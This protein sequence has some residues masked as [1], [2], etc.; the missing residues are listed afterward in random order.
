MKSRSSVILLVAVIFAVVGYSVVNIFKEPERRTPQRMPGQGAP[1]TLHGLV[2]PENDFVRDGQTVGIL[3]DR[4]GISLNAETRES[5]DMA[6]AD[7]S[8]Q[9]FV[10]PSDDI[11]LAKFRQNR[12]GATGA[13]TFRS[14]LVIYTWDKV[15]DALVRAGVARLDRSGCYTLDVRKL[16][17]MQLRGTTWRSLGLPSVSGSVRVAST[18]PVGSSCGRIWCALIASAET[19]QNLG[20][21]HRLSAALPAI[22]RS[23]A[24]S[25]VH[26]ADAQALFEQFVKLGMEGQPLAIGFEA[27]FAEHRMGFGQ[28]IS[29]TKHAIRILYPEPAIWIDHTLIPLTMNGRRLLLALDDPNLLSYS[30]SKYGFRTPSGAGSMYQSSGIQGMPMTIENAIDVPTPAEMKEIEA[31]LKRV[32]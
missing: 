17:D 26:G 3:R 10:W 12:P 19:G 30:R 1:V 20:D 25:Y 14:P 24:E 8:G 18:D 27:E 11:A 15:A 16:A 31:V 21:P 22:R 7:L 29:G 6:T 4:Y 32:K 9:D 23:C 28:P 13:T 5:A 2:S